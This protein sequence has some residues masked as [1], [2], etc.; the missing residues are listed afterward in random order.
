MKPKVS[1]PKG[2]EVSGMKRNGREEKERKGMKAAHLE[3]R[4]NQGSQSDLG[5]TLSD[6][7]LC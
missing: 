2:R 4:K 6:N 3:G 5:I 1:C 7:G